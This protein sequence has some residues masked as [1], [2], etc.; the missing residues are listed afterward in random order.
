[1]GNDSLE[2]WFEN[3]RKK[4]REKFNRVVDNTKKEFFPMQEKKIKKIYKS[5][6]DDF[7]ADYKPHFYN[8]RDN[9]SLYKLLKCRSDTEHIYMSFDPSEISYRNGYAGEDGLYRTVFVEGWHGG[10]MVHNS[11]LYPVG[12]EGGKIKT[13]DGTYRY[14]ES[15]GKEVYSPYECDNIKYG[16][17]EANRASISP[18]DD[19]NK[20]FDDYQDTEFEEDFR[21]LFDKNLRK[22]NL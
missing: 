3:D 18:L 19:F 20:R 16:W 17:I 12:Y 13:Y 21:D 4:R 11:M 5:V 15:L 7:Y 9:G 8:R 22:E 1:M 14:K 6:I 2:S 10:A